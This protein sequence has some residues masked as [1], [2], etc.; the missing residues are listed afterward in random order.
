M[1]RTAFAAPLLMLGLAGC[2]T[3]DG[4]TLSTG[5]RLELVTTHNCDLTTTV[6]LLQPQKGADYRPTGITSGPGVCNSIIRTGGQVAASAV[7]PGGGT[8][9]GNGSIQVV[10]TG[11]GGGSSSASSTN[12]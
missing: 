4:L 3:T 11:G 2:A 9:F 7:M 12:Q 8:T 6:S 10:A 1:K 5:Q